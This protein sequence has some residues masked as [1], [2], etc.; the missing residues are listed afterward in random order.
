MC[1]VAT[2]PS[3]P[4]IA[5][6]LEGAGRSK[7]YVKVVMH[8]AWANTRLLWQT[9]VRRVKDRLVLTPSPSTLPSLLYRLAEFITASNGVI[10]G[11]VK[12]EPLPPYTGDTCPDCQRCN[13]SGCEPH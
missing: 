1:S 13:G 12:L 7:G 4:G 6:P 3:D 2:N 9:D 11:F 8:E 5:L 10:A